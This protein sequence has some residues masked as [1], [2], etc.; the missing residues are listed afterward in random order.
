VH[1]NCGHHNGGQPKS[2]AVDNSSNHKTLHGSIL[3]LS[4]VNWFT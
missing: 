1:R 4:Q 3:A 2:Q